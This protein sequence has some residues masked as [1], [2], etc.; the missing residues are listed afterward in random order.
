MLDSWCVPLSIGDGLTK[1]TAEFRSLLCRASTEWKHCKSNSVASQHRTD[2]AQRHEKFE[3]VVSK[4]WF[5]IALQ[6]AKDSTMR[7]LISNL[8]MQ[9]METRSTSCEKWK[10]ACLYVGLTRTRFV[11]AKRF[12]R[13]GAQREC[14][15]QNRNGFHVVL[16]GMWC[17]CN[18]QIAIFVRL[19]ESA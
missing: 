17:C 8:A 12:I 11:E 6:I 1:R 7:E 16:F 9:H 5:A 18:K 3:K 19:G 10:D 14:S 2:N 13:C 15:S 4:Q